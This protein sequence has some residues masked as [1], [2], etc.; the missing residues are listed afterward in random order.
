VSITKEHAAKLGGKPAIVCCR[1]VKGTTIN[2][3]D[4]ED[5]AIFADLE[6]SGLDH[7]NA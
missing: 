2:P 7:H 1:T 5:P 4:L 6:E 3:A